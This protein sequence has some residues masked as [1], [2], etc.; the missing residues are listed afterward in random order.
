M[1]R[2]SMESQARA[3]RPEE[4]PW[5]STVNFNGSQHQTLQILG[6]IVPLNEIEYGLGCI[7]IRSPYTLYSI[8]L[9]GT[10]HFYGYLVSGTVGCKER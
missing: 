3:R 1:S 8:C 2:V 4:G 9:R 7:I 6:F 5:P 10:I